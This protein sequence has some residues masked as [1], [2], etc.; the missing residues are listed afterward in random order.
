M[1]REIA[2]RGTKTLM[3]AVLNNLVSNAIRYA[4]SR[5][6]VSVERTADQVTISVKDDGSGINENDLPHL[7]QPMYK[8]KKG[9]LGM[10]LPVAKEAAD[11]MGGSIRAENS[12]DGGA[13]FIVAL[14]AP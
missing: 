10:G 11:Y 7:F 6:A 4:S 12:P 8:G 9:N 13:V 3:E 2:V 14:P 1:D 5:V